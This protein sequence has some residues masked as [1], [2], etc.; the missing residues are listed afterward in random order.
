MRRRCADS[1]HTS[2]EARARIRRHPPNGAAAGNLRGAAG[3]LLYAP[4]IAT[5]RRN[6][7]PRHRPGTVRQGRQGPRVRVRASKPGKR[8]ATAHW[9]RNGENEKL[10]R[11]TDS[12]LTDL[13]R[14]TDKGHQQHRHLSGI[15]GVDRRELD[16]VFGDNAIARPG[17]EEVSLNGFTDLP[18][19][20]GLQSVGGANSSDQIT[21]TIKSPAERPTS[22]RP[23]ETPVIYTRALR[24][25]K[26]DPTATAPYRNS[27]AP[28]A[29]DSVNILGLPE[30]GR[31]KAQNNTKGAGADAPAPL[32]GSFQLMRQLSSRLIPPEQSR[33]FSFSGPPRRP[34]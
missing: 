34:P 1:A 26:P 10:T 31:W 29:M 4:P 21:G 17:K 27:V 16:S 19:G 22:R 12:G 25:S 13:P 28:K 15:D 30:P 9:K 8:C 6:R 14:T 24:N 7:P 3:E 11:F 18:E 5:A 23:G 33:L 20:V 32:Q 2:L